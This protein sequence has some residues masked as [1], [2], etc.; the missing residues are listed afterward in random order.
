MQHRSCAVDVL[1]EALDAARVRE[2]L[3]LAVALVDELDLG[4]VVEERQLADALG[5]DVEVVLDVAERL[6]EA[7]KCTS[8]PRRS[9]GPMSASGDTGTPRRN[10]IWW[11]LPSRQILSLSQSDSALTT[12]T[13]T[14]CRPPET[15]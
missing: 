3:A 12:D 5:E 14:P 7:M 13:P 8:V 9:D 4:A 1:D 11:N 15:L 10:S 2:V 6:A